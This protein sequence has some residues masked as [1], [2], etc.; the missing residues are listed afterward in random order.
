MG[1]WRHFTLF[2]HAVFWP[3]FF[4]GLLCLPWPLNFII[5]LG[6]HLVLYAGWPRLRTSANSLVFG[7][8]TPIAVKWMV[9]TVLIS[10]GGL[11]AWVLL[12]HPDL[13]NLLHMVPRGGP[14]LLIAT[15]VV[16]SVLNA[17]WEEF[18]L[19]GI[20]WKSLEKVFRRGW[21]VNTGQAA[22]FGVMHVGGF[23]RGWIGVLMATV[24]GFVLGVIRKESRG[25][26]API[27]THIFADATIFMVLYFIAVGILSVN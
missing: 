8:F 25:L 11:L 20:G 5:P 23:P 17:I 26:L 19:K 9:P 2:A 10:Y 6:A 21:A 7:R 4:A 22:L 12:F 15:G 14:I 13:S 16:F 1:S 24:Y 3:M 27:A 18:I